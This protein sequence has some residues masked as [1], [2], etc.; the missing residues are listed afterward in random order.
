M[1]GGKLGRPESATDLRLLPIPRHSEP[2]YIVGN[3]NVTEHVSDVLCDNTHDS[4]AKTVAPQVLRP[5]R[6]TAET[7]HGASA[8]GKRVKLTA[9]SQTKLSEN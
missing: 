4:E 3:G 1:R 6:A 5:S 7:S 2:E 8:Y 9:S